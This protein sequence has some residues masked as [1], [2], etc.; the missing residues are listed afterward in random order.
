MNTHTL[1]FKALDFHPGL[2]VTIRNGIKWASALVPGDELQL[3]ETGKEDTVV[4][5][6]KALVTKVVL[7]DNL[8]DA[9]LEYEHSPHCRT[10]AGLEAAMNRA[11]GSGQWGPDLSVVFFWV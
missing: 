4:K 8:P 2:N 9:W 3:V 11:Y 6:G 10:R 5:L 1:Q 7:Y